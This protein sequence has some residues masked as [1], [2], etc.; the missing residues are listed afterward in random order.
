LNNKLN[1]NAVL[2]IVKRF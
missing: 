1:F 2:N